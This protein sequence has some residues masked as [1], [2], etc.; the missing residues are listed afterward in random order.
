MKVSKN[1]DIREFVPRSLWE[2]R[3]NQCKWYVSSTVIHL[4]QFYKDF[5]S[6]YYGEEV[7]VTVNDWLWG[8]SFHNRGYRYPS[9]EVGS[10]LSFHRGGLCTAFDCEI[11]IKSTGKEIDPDE[12]RTVIIDHEKEFMEH[13]LTTLEGGKYAPGWIHSDHRNTGLDKI[14]IVGDKR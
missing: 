5:F 9:T 12:I 7:T 8:G 2:D 10:P 13:G 6:E 14:L 1:F 4:A 11:R 3:G